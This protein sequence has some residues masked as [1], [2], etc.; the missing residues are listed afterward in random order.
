MITPLLKG[1]QRH[2]GDIL[3]DPGDA[4]LVA[5]PRRRVDATAARTKL[6]SSS[7][8][9]GLVS[10]MLGLIWVCP[11][12]G[13]DWGRP[14]ARVCILL[15]GHGP[16][17]WCLDG[18]ERPGCRVM[19]WWRW[20]SSRVRRWRL[21][22]SLM[23]ARRFGAGVWEAVRGR[24]ARLLG[25]GN[26]RSTQ[27]A[28]Q[29]LAQTHQQLTTVTPGSGLEQAKQ[30]QAERWADRFADLLDEDQPRQGRPA[31]IHLRPARRASRRVHVSRP[32]ETAALDADG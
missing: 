17:F 9:Y 15:F 26:D 27:V 7:R 22:R 16:G 2:L 31:M 23:C 32:H 6:M 14:I 29:W 11:D 12:S 20:R 13:G 1:S 24:F 28:E 18:E 10:V 19:C 25:R 5:V 30:V 8:T 21:R 3:A 4:G